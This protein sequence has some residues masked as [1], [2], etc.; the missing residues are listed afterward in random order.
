MHPWCHFVLMGDRNSS[1][2]PRGLGQ[3]DRARALVTAARRRGLGVGTEG[4]GKTFGGRPLEATSHGKGGGAKFER[5]H[6]VKLLPPDVTGQIP[7]VRSA[8]SHA[9]Q[10]GSRLTA[11]VGSGA[12]RQAQ[13]ALSRC[14]IK[15][16]LFLRAFFFGVGGWVEANHK[17]N[18]KFGASPINKDRATE[19]DQQAFGPR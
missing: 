4:S 11:V 15:M 7:Q 16:G 18:H 17:D 14:T 13:Q 10:R 3:V 19:C 12:L 8:V 5:K 1:H 2:S 9:G 6:F